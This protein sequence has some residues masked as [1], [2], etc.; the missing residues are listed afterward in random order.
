M[1]QQY[2][3]GGGGGGGGGVHL[4]ISVGV[5]RHKLVFAALQAIQ[6]LLC[7]QNSVGEICTVMDD[8][9]KIHSIWHLLRS[10]PG[11]SRIP[12]RPGKSGR[13]AIM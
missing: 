2:G 8:C 5:G 7:K 13:I 6:T 11:Y 4:E 3:G 1:Y 9:S 10:G 12:I